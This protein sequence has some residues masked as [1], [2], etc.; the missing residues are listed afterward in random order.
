MS[1]ALRIPERVERRARWVLDT[2]GASDFQLGT[3][4]LFRPEP[5]EQVERG[6]LPEGD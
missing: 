3:D 6:E 4:L 1:A 5:W 2:I